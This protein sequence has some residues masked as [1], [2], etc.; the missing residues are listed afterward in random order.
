MKNGMIYVGETKTDNP[1]H[2]P[3]SPRLRTTLA[4]IPRR[5]GAEHVFVGQAK[6]GRGQQIGKPGLPFDRVDT[7]FLNACTR[8]GIVSFR[9]HDL[10]HT[11]ASHMV[12][13]GVPLK[14]VGEL[15]GHTTAAMTE[16][17]SHLTPEHKRAAIEKLSAAY[18]GETCYKS[19][20]NLEG[21]RMKSRNPLIFW[22]DGRT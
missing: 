4:G 14:T 8:A 13:A 17:Y 11:A 18:G 7:A 6:V 2:V 15:L 22:S 3:M 5:L 1:R 20:T 12:M 21:L 19:A 9:F 10:R 16:R